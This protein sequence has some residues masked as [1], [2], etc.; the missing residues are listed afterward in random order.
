[1]RVGIGYD[2]HRLVAGR[3]LVLGGVELEAERGL[4]GHSDADVLLHALIDA[5]LGAAGLGD[6]G[7]H[8][9]PGD[10]RWQDADSAE[11]LRFVA[12]ELAQAGWSVANIDANVLAERPRL[13]PQI[14]AMRERIARTLGVPL[15][16]VS[17][18]AKT[19]EG[20][21][22]VGEGLVISAQAVALIERA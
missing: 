3:R 12:D 15:G 17:V 8:F 22:P 16:R 1:M 4:E 6:I 5:L 13:A 2:T 19:N 21:G 9:P 18:K 10:P 20:L 14:A 7:G 11:L